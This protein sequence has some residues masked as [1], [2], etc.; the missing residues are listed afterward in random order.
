MVTLRKAFAALLSL[1]VPSPGWYA[2]LTGCAL[3]LV[4]KALG[5]V[6]DTDPAAPYVAVV[7]AVTG[8]WQLERGVRAE[9]RRRRVRTDDLPGPTA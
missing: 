9:L 3:I 6:A 8:V 4:A 2:I 7:L 5:S 1:G